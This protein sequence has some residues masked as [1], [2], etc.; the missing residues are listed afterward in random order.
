[1]TI[2]V[3]DHDFW[4]GQPFL[5]FI[6]LN[7]SFHSTGI[8]IQLSRPIISFAHSFSS[9]WRAEEEH[10]VYLKVLPRNSVT[11]GHDED[12]EFSQ[13]I[14]GEKRNS[15]EPSS[16]KKW[17]LLSLGIRMLRI[18]GYSSNTGYPTDRKERNFQRK[19]SKVPFFHV[20]LLWKVGQKEKRII[21]SFYFLFINSLSSLSL[22]LF[23]I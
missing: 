17:P 13:S 19:K 9:Q 10:T 8:Q 1:M 15:N 22:G 18:F 20:L 3:N 14:E 21:K 12:D 6:S 2:R 23:H 5:V 7:I 11:W 16:I 4:S